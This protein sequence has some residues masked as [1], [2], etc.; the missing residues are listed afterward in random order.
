MSRTYTYQPAN[1]PWY[2]NN[3]PR[4]LPKHSKESL[5]LLTFM[6]ERPKACLQVKTTRVPSGLSETKATLIHRIGDH[7]QYNYSEEPITLATV[8][9]L[10][11]Y[12]QRSYYYN[13]QDPI[14]TF[15]ICEYT[16]PHSPETYTLPTQAR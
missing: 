15:I 9:R 11:P 13:N 7:A 16:F 6:Q 10:I 3:T 2:Y 4:K 14:S 5:R 1:R 8:K 12:L